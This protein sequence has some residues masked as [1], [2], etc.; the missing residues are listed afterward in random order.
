MRYRTE[1]QEGSAYSRSRGKTPRHN[2]HG[3]RHD[4]VMDTD[5]YE[6][7]LQKLREAAKERA[8]YLRYLARVLPT[9]LGRTQALRDEAARQLAQ[10]AE[11]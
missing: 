8:Q 4:L 3:L 10:L 5:K 1:A 7:A 11:E 2:L 6:D 9:D